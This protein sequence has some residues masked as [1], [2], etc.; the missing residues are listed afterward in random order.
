M[1]KA[2]LNKYAGRGEEGRLAVGRIAGIVGISAN[3]L[4]FAGKIIAGLAADSVSVTADA[5]NNLSD[6]LSSV[7]VLVGYILCA[8]PAD[9]EHPFG[10]AR[11]EYLC[12]LF[13]SVIV[14]VLG[15]ELFKSSVEKFFAEGEETDLS[16]LAIVIMAAAIFVKLLLAVFYN[17]LGKAINS[18]SLKA[19][20]AD[21]VGDVIATAAVIVGLVLTPV[22][23][24]Y[25]DAVVGTGVSVY[26]I[27]LGIKL[28]REASGTLL[29]EAPDSALVHTIADR[30]LA[31]E[32]VLGIHDLVIHSY[33]S[34]ALYATV[35]VEVDA[36]DDIML[37][38]DRMDNIEADFLRDMSIHLVIHMDPICVSDP[39]TVENRDRIAEIVRT[40]SG[41][42]GKKITMHDFRMV[43]GVTHSNLIFDVAVGID[44]PIT[45]RELSERIADMAKK[46]DGKFNCVIT[47]DREYDSTRF[48]EE[49]E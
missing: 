36:D 44:F 34:G 3:V 47:V 24:K 39:E 21:S 16:I 49:Q 41:E 12:G 38:H 35:H 43:K 4:L 6:A 26:I 10:H 17:S 29:G 25:A 8:R 18:S 13:I 14:S 42:T 23:G 22:F 45:D 31:Y 15:L 33:G 1:I 40:V 19:S 30:V 9:R 46:I 27:I 7:L 32:G 48:G 2:L 20:A 37:I 28:I 11:M 5:F